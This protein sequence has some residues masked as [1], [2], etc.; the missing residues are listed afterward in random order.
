[1]AATDFAATPG[2]AA[3]DEPIAARAYR[4][5]FWRLMPFLMLCYVA[6]YMDRV[7]IGFAK[8]QMQQELGFSE[9]VFG[10]GSGIFFLGYFFF[11]VPSNI[12]MHKVGARA[13]I[14]RI[15]ISW[16]LLSAAFIWVKSAPTFYGLRFILGLAEAGFYPG[17][18]L[19]LTYWFP[20][21]WRG[22]VIAVLMSAI[23]VSSIFGNP[24]S[25]WV[26]DAM[27]GLAGVAGW[28][29]MF[30]VEAAPAVL[31]GIAVL[32]YLDNS[33]ASAKWLDADE[34]RVL[35]EAIEADRKSQVGG[36][37]DTWAAFKDARVWLMC[38]IYFCFIL[39]QYG[40][41]FWMPTLLKTAG[42]KGN[43]LIGFVSAIPYLVTL[44]MM[45]LF[46]WSADKRRER[47]WHL[48]IPALIGAVGFVVAPTA[49]NV[50]VAIAALSLAAAGAITCAPLFWSLPTA[51]LAGAGAAAGIAVVNS[52]GNLAGFVAPYVIGYAKDATGSAAVGM[53][54][55]A[56]GLVVGAIA[57]LLTPAKLVNR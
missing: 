10:L 12:L 56:G 57:T 22:R 34:K 3:E 45:N 25:G 6:S 50:G 39:G 27:N 5:V 8:L 7:N 33:I 23:P 46:G 18:I 21:R 55:I 13:W 17:V 48:V 47:R 38:L 28:K 41:N 54:A 37:H 9:T 43:T 1:M 51:F 4:K 42:V 44:V 49:P 14:A 24:L 16:G 35:E 40:M 11:E 15:M 32:F 29:W 36:T 20:A 31:I 19:Y 2:I 52:V 53:Y 30:V 26:M